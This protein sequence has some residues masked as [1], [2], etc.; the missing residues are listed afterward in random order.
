MQIGIDFGTTR[1]VVAAADRGNYPILAFEAPDGGHYD[2]FPSLIAV[3][4]EQRRYGWEAWSHQQDPEWT[5]IRS[6]KRVLED[7]GPHTIIQAGS[8]AFPLMQLLHEMAEALKSCLPSGTFQAI[9]G[10][11]ANANSN[12]RFLTSEMFRLAGFD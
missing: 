9:L 8:Q 1:T 7:A 10:V 12:Q 2:W 6:I 11:P 4:G 3:Q 5:T